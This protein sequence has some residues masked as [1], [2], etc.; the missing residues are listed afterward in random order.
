MDPKRCIQDV[1]RCDLCDNPAPSMYCDFCNKYLCKPCVGKHLSDLSKEH[2]VVPFEKRGSTPYYPKCQKHLS[3]QCELHCK[4]CDIPICVHCVS[5]GEH[6]G[7]EA[8]DILIRFESIKEVIHRDLSELENVIYP[9]YEDI[10]S[11]IPAR[12]A[13]LNENSEKLKTA[14]NRRGEELHRE[15][16]TISQKIKADLVELNTKHIADLNTQE[17]DIQHTIS[18]ITQTIEDLRN[19][20]DS[21]DVSIACAYKSRNDKFRELPPKLKVCLPT[22]TP[23][24]TNKEGI[25]QQFGSFSAFSNETEETEEHIFAMDSPATETSPSD[26]SF[27]DKP[28]IITEINSKYG[29]VCSISCLNDEN[30]WTSG[31]DKIMRLYNLHGE[32][33]KSVQ[34]K[35]GIK[36]LFMHDITVTMKGD[37]VYTDFD[38]RTVN[39]VK[40]THIYKVI[41]LRGWRPRNICCTSSGKLLVVMDSD[42]DKQTKVVRYSG[43]KVERSIQFNDYGQPLYSSGSYYIKYIT[44]N[45]NFDI[46][47]SDNKAGALVVVNQA[48][49]HRFTYTGHP[50]SLIKRLFSF[51][52]SLFTT[53]ELFNPRGITTD[54]Q[55]RILTADW[56]TNCIHILD[57]DGQ[58]LRYIDNCDIQTPWGLCVDTSDN[59]FVAEYATEKVKK[60]KYYK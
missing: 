43:S 44:E 9:K 40:N 6:L 60:I 15:I 7:H 1:L 46:C 20:L 51:A 45:R 27:I 54:S 47:V 25:Y 57:Q 34:T 14:I 55:S 52:G 42:D 50:G 12:K 48:G 58:F 13:D 3:K 17:S 36:P 53:K 10:L 29:R 23:Q 30:I 19:I 38:D 8:V 2:K 16:D 5:S 32:L 39:I 22:F 56:T 26:R 33:V 18:G 11:N 37:L 4:P 21:N 41:K 59:L 35:S 24:K 31:R 49:K 28:W